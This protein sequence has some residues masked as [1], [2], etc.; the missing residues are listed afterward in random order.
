MIHRPQRL[1][2]IM[3]ECTS[4]GL[5]VKR[6]RLVQPYI[7]KEPNM[8]MIEAVKGGGRET[9][10]LPTLIIY[11]KDGSYTEEVLKIYGKCS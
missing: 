7:D 3:E 9:R 5:E 11:N 4:H 1:T 8:V 6:L 2:E 10:V